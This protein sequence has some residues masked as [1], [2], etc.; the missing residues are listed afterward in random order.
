MEWWT[1]DMVMIWISP[2]WK[3]DDSM[4]W[5]TFCSD[6]GSKHFLKQ[7]T[8]QIYPFGDPQKYHPKYTRCPANGT[9]ML[10]QDLGFS[11][12]EA[13]NFIHC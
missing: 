5:P 7:Y 12:K 2:H 10:I 13:I 11:R 3:F 8:N 4:T 1:G 9:H 6:F